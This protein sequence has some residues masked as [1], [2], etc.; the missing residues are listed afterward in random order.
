M[1]HSVGVN[2]K[3]EGS[4]LG[5]FIL[6]NFG[7]PIGA[8]LLIFYLLTRKSKNMSGSGGGGGILGF[9][10]SRAK[11]VLQQSIKVSF[12][13]VAGID[14]AKAELQEVVDF[15]KNPKKY[16]RLGAKV[17]RGV[18]LVGPPGTGKTLLARATAG[19]ANVPFFQVTGSDFVEMFV[20]VGA[21]RVR[22]L[23][24]KAQKKAP[25]IVFIDEIDSLGRRRGGVGMIG[26]NSESEQTL[27]Q[28]LSAMDGFNNDTS[29]MVMGATNRP[30]IL[31]EAL[32]RPG[33]FDRH[34]TVP[35]PDVAG[36]EAILKVH[37]KK[38][39]MN[40]TVN[41]AQVARETTN[42]S[43]SD[44]ENLLNEAAMTATR[45]DRETIM[46]DD[47]DK[48][49][50]RITLGA[51]RTSMKMSA[52]DKKRVAYH[53]AGHA[54]VAMACPGA[55]PVKKITIIPHGMALGLTAQHNEEDRKV[56]SIGYLKARLA[57]CMG[58]RAAEQLIFKDTS[59]GASND[60]FHASYL[61]RQ[62]VLLFGMSEAIGPLSVNMPNKQWSEESPQVSEE[63]MRLIDAEIKK[64]LLEAETEAKNILTI[65]QLVL[66]KLVALLLV[67]ETINGSEAHALYEKYKAHDYG[68][69]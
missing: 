27:N 30:E 37:A 69:E 62:M 36:R 38:F 12:N 52:E 60:L 1:S 68:I 59:T 2:Y 24:E 5:L 66:E 65:N 49:I 61:A 41:L 31:D 15:L 45:N 8:M 21:A 26:N 16:S 7:L 18:L 10:Q 58:G 48:A 53:E 32:L 39:I 40:E 43:G 54:I 14:E 67:K 47:V 46:M 57:V 25:C 33:R 34:I 50:D 3:E 44:L 13:D 9:G 42:F 11:E 63:T 64:F 4:S 6:F 17:S 55:D 29:V 23:F 28:L 56:Q 35:L 19:E 22:N 20:G 51:A